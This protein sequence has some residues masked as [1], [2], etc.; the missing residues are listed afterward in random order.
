MNF[1]T[2]SKTLRHL[3][4][5]ALLIAVCL[6]GSTTSFAQDSSQTSQDATQKVQKLGKAALEKCPHRL[7][8]V[9]FDMYY[10]SVIDCPNVPVNVLFGYDF[11]EVPTGCDENGECYYQE[12]P[13]VQVDPPLGPMLAKP[14]EVAEV[15][16]L[17]DLPK[18]EVKFANNTKTVQKTVGLDGWGTTTPF[19][20]KTDDGRYFVLTSF[21]DLNKNIY[22]N[23]AREF[24]KEVVTEKNAK[25][26]KDTISC[27]GLKYTLL[28]KAK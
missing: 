3:M 20:V 26:E 16:V 18:I 23:F 6:L 1:T 10:F 5:P 24:E 19:L 8:F 28:K 22:Y 11:S 25:I 12:L 9:H 15:K 7:L 4:F 17:E 2:L 27:D 13:Y 21:H 14:K